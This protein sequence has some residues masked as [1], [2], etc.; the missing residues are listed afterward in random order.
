MSLSL[1]DLKGELREGYLRTEE[2]LTGM[3]AYIARLEKRL[4]CQV[5]RVDVLEGQMAAMTAALYSDAPDESD[6]GPR[7]IVG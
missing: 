1:E 7:I 3:D 4:E 6:Q 5:K 2:V